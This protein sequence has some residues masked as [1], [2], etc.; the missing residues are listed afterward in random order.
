MKLYA[1]AWPCPPQS[2][3]VNLKPWLEWVTSE[4]EEEETQ[5]TLIKRNRLICCVERKKADAGLVP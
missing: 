5:P 2:L 1:L 4:D 3:N